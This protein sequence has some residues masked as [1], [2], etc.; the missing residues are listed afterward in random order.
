M[1]DTKR[2]DVPSL[3]E[4]STS[5][6]STCTVFAAVRLGLT[7]TLALKEG[8]ATAKELAEELSCSQRGM[9]ALLDGLVSI[10]LLVKE[11][12]RYSLHPEAKP[13][14]TPGHF[15]DR[16]HFLLHM[17]DLIAQWDRLDDVVRNGCPANWTPGDADRP[18]KDRSHY[19]LAMIDVARPQVKGLAARLG[20]Q[21]GQS[22]LDLG[23][24]HGLYAYTFADE[25]DGLT[26]T[27]YDLPGS[28]PFFDE[29]GRQHAAAGNV[30]FRAGDMTQEVLDLGGPYDVVWLSQ[31]LH[32]QSPEVCASVLTAATNALNPGGVL[33]IQEFILEDNRTEPR[34]P[35]LFNINML[36][37]NRAGQSYSKSELRAM[38]ETAGLCNVTFEGETCSGTPSS[39]MRG[40]KPS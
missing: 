7:Q 39:L 25:T 17:S 30:G 40:E 4:F 37:Q 24:G 31:V 2:W 3:M 28:R 34:W 35:A 23:G 36:L 20:L 12:G 32:V 1:T 27:V 9:D 10:E 13:L 21:S 19:Y 16:T 26:A 6:W 5:Y 15:L 33:W 38:M 11:D 22:V 14:L 8:G 29:E 18:P